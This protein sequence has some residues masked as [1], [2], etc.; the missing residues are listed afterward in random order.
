MRIV[1]ILNWVIIISCFT[2]LCNCKKETPKVASPPDDISPILPELLSHYSYQL[3]SYWIYHDSISGYTDSMYVSANFITANSAHSTSSS[4]Y[5]V[6]EV[7]MNMVNILPGIPDTTV[8]N[9]ELYN[10]YFNI[11]AFE[12]S[13]Y[14]SFN[15]PLTKGTDNVIDLIPQYTLN[16]STY[17]NV[18]VLKVFNDEFYLN[19]SLGIIK[20]RLGTG[21]TTAVN[22]IWELVR[23]KIVR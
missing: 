4:K 14:E 18:G 5:Y 6:N 12:I 9:I 23:Y 2:L 8:L 22:H 16:A 1:K 3:G 17:A 13:R 15:Y 11:I 20:M 7:R 10:S 21:D 19:D